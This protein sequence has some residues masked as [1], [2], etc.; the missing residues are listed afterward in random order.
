MVRRCSIFVLVLIGFTA[1]AACPQTAAPDISKTIERLHE[2][3]FAAFDKGDGATMDR[4]EAPNLV[5]VFQ[6][7]MIWQKNE[8]RAGKQK[9]T[10]VTSRSLS[11]VQVRQFGDTAILTGLLTNKDPKTEET[12]PTTV[13][14]LR[15]NNN[16]LVASAQWGRNI[17]HNGSKTE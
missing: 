17:E 6:D 11:K 12:V 9:P 5:L 3:W 16:W 15:R 8:P 4:M 2:Q 7:G 14:W 1:V 13:V 10:G